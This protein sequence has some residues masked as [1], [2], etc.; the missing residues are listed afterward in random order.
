[1]EWHILWMHIHTIWQILV[2]CRVYCAKVVVRTSS[3]GFLVYF[4]AALLCRTW[5][6]AHCYRCSVV[7]VCVSVGHNHELCKNGRTDWG[8][9][10]DMD[11]DGPKEP[12]ILGRGPG[13]QWKGQFW[14]HEKCREYPAWAKVIRYMAA[15]M[16]SLT[17]S[18]VCIELVARCLWSVR[19]MHVIRR[20]ACL[21]C[22]S[23]FS[24]HQCSRRWPAVPSDLIYSGGDGGFPCR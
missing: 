13:P 20:S 19:W 2:V 8:A 14:G 21:F 15:A 24:S 23:L 11:S 7:C 16:W 10:W 5:D 18:T 1:M 9:V 22:L 4:L 3:V 17:L 12:I 6:A